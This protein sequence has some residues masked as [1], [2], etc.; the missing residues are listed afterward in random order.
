MSGHQKQKGCT[1]CIEILHGALQTPPSQHAC[2]SL[3][4][5]QPSTS[6]GSLL[7]SFCNTVYEPQ[8]HF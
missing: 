1:A 5:G 6:R 2:P 3:M 8:L 4:A 7:V